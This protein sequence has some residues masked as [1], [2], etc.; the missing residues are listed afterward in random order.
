M[1]QSGGMS[2]VA[3]RAVFCFL[4]FI[5]A[6]RARYMGYSIVYQAHVFFTLK[7]KKWNALVGFVV[8]VSTWSGLSV[9]RSESSSWQ[10]CLPGILP[11]EDFMRASSVC[12]SVHETEFRA[13]FLGV[14]PNLRATEGI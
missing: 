9:T 8:A 13:I 12:R 6:H 1:G 10:S 3:L 2:R 4:S 11:R 7:G 5:D 14:L